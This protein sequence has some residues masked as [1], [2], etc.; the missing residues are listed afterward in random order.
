VKPIVVVI[1]LV[2]GSAPALAEDKGSIAG[3]Y[4]LELSEVQDSCAGSGLTLPPQ[5]ALTLIS[6]GTGLRVELAD[7]PAMKGSLDKGG[8][9]QAEASREKTRLEG[10]TGSFSIAGRVTGREA[11]VVIVVEL[12]KGASPSCTQSWNGKGKRS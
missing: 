10:M 11:Q 12:F 9:F 7:F 1:A 2:L 6:D 3:R 8:K 5:A 4:A